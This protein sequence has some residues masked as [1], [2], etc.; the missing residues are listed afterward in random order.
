MRTVILESLTALWP[1]MALGAGALLTVLA[2]AF[3]PDRKH[4]FVVAIGTVLVTALGLMKVPVPPSTATFFDLVICDP[5]GFAFRVIAVLIVAFSVMMIMGATDSPKR[6][7]GE[8]V[9]LTLFMGMGLMLM[10]QANH[11]LMLYLALEM[12]SLCSYLLVGFGDDS[13]SSEA[14]LKFLVFGALASGILLF[15]L[16]LIF[17]LTGRLTFPGIQEV[18][19]SV[20]RSSY[21]LLVLSMVMVAAGMAF[22]IS[23]FPFHMWTPDAYE[24]AP[25]PVAALLSVGP[26]AAALALLVRLMM[27]L[28]PAWPIVEPMFVALTVA[29][30]TFGNLVALVQTNVKR[31]LAYSTIA[32]VGYLLVGFLVHNTQGLHAMLFYL[33]AYVFMNLGAFACV[34]VVKHSTGSESLDGFSGLAQRSP[35]TAVLCTLFFL[36]LAGIPPLLGFFGKFLLLGAAM[37]S[38]RHMLAIIVVVNTIVS[39]YYYVRVI[40]Q[41]VLVAPE[42]TSPAVAPNGAQWVI[43]GC[44]V[45]TLVLGIF[46]NGLLA[47]LQAFAVV[48][49]L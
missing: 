44:G 34:Q 42:D 27:A 3:W 18:L 47:S 37:E 10:A 15:G 41:M 36:S 33:V 24:G 28:S 19:P 39:L 8:Y 9:S 38:A 45:A 14:A 16:S 30:M 13:R 49:L 5:F 11:M 29:T 43:W 48:S 22:K 4:S 7:K 21:P 31:M 23:L 1:E 25:V 32:Q 12:V 17:A 6:F 26:K 35:V 20:G 2:A 46:P 40:R